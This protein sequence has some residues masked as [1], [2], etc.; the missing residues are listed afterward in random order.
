MPEAFDSTTLTPKDLLGPNNHYST[1]SLVPVVVP[2]FQRPFSWKKDQ[3][4]D[5]WTDVMFAL[6]PP[7]GS[8]T[9]TEEVSRAYFLGPLVIMPKPADAPTE[10]ALLDGQ[11]RL[12]VLTILAALLR[13]KAQDLSR[14]LQA[15]DPDLANRAGA[16]ALRIHESYVLLDEHTGS[17]ALVLNRED[18]LFFRQRIQDFPPQSPRAT[19]PSHRLIVRAKNLLNKLLSEHLGPL[20]HEDRLEEIKRLARVFMHSL[21][22]VTISVRS[23]REAFV[24]F[25]TLNDR[26]LH[27]TVADLLLNFLMMRSPDGQTRDAVRQ[28]W[29]ETVQTLGGAELKTFLRHY[30]TSHRGDERRKTLFDAIKDALSERTPFESP[31]DLARGI[32]SAS[33]TYA[34]LLEP[35]TSRFQNAAPYVRALTKELGAQKALPL[36]LAAVDTFGPNTREFIKLVRAVIALVVRHSVLGNQDPAQLESVLYSLGP[37][38]RRETGASRALSLAIEELRQISPSDNTLL[39]QTENVYIENSKAARYLLRSIA[40]KAQ[41]DVVPLSE[42]AFS[43]EHVFPQR[44]SASMWPNRDTLLGLEGHLGNLLWIESALNAEA[45]NRG[46]EVKRDIY[47]RSRVQLARELAERYESWT[48]EAILERARYLVREHALVLWPE[49]LTYD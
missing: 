48:P 32:R 7:A 23:E 25:E 33:E 28:A 3:V 39:S 14:G 13:D 26:G 42:D 19:L 45:G 24:I 16:Q 5:L 49:A 9:T 40:E 31:L 38:M 34:D 8:A 18:K 22:L 20:S 17:Y 30:W 2:E 11:Q 6:Q 41:Q 44:S 1:T 10:I 27:L 37:R 12:A 46:Y 43:L 35:T 15:R 29:H 36:L 47:R 21:S 4:L